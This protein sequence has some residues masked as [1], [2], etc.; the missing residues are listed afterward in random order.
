MAGA[1]I[2][3]SVAS[4]LTRPARLTDAIALRRTGNAASGGDPG[5]SGCW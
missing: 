5:C 1:G 3:R 4:R 2:A